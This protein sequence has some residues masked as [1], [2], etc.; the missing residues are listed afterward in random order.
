MCERGLARKNATVYLDYSLAVILDLAAQTF[1]FRFKKRLVKFRNIRIGIF[2]RLAHF[3]E[4]PEGPDQNRCQE[5]LGG[6]LLCRSHKLGFEI[7]ARFA[8]PFEKPG[9]LIRFPALNYSSR[10]RLTLAKLEG[11]DSQACSH[12]TGCCRM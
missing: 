3:F 7:F 11:F 9:D 1:Q 12:T 5:L 2:A 6:D 4:V 8:H 10:W